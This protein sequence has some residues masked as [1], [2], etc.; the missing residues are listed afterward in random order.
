MTALQRPSADLGNIVRMAF[1]PLRTLE[2]A[3]LHGVPP[4][5]GGER[6]EGRRVLWKS[7]LA[8]AFE[9]E[10]IACAAVQ[11]NPGGYDCTADGW[12]DAIAPVRFCPPRLSA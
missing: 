3:L 6:E 10:K 4:G 2:C 12:G 8:L 1:T 7:W 11:P 5:L 9:P